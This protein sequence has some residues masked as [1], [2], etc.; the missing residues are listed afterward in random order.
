MIVKIKE[1]VRIMLIVFAAGLLVFSF[2]IITNHF[3]EKNNIKYY[4]LNK[5]Y[6]DGVFCEK[7]VVDIEGLNQEEI[8]ARII[9]LIANDKSIKDLL[10]P[11]SEAPAIDTLIINEGSALLSFKDNYM[12]NSPLSHQLF[13]SCLIKSF[14]STGWINDVVFLG[15]DLDDPRIVPTKYTIDSVVEDF[16]KLK[17]VPVDIYYVSSTGNSLIKET[18]YYYENYAEDMI[19]FIMRQISKG[20]IDGNYSKIL[21]NRFSSYSAHVENGLCT[22][23][24][25]EEFD[26]WEIPNYVLPKCFIQSIVNSLCSSP[27]INSVKITFSYKF[28]KLYNGIDISN[29][30]YFDDSLVDNSKK[31]KPPV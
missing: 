31:S 20:P 22:I 5:E 19:S 25:N 21:P 30:F 2:V 26:Q 14:C 8:A 7:N 12:F 16:D 18:K 15:R 10:L 11:T 4:V 6:E 29:P 28:D 3:I 24:F 1:C 23:T 27:D 17:T 13:K 9:D